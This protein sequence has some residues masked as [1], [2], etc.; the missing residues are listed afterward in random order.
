M[1]AVTQ[2]EAAADRHPRPLPL[3]SR[4]G[5]CCCLAAGAPDHHVGQWEEGIKVYK[6]SKSFYWGHYLLHPLS[7]YKGR[8]ISK[9]SLLPHH[10]SYRL[11]LTLAPPGAATAAPPAAPA[12]PAA[13]AT[14]AGNGVGSRAL[15]PPAP[16]AAPSAPSAAAAAGSNAQTTSAVVASAVLQASAAPATPAA[17]AEAE[18]ALLPAAVEAALLDAFV[19]YGKAAEQPPPSPA[20]HCDSTTAAV[21]GVGLPFQSLPGAAAVPDNTPPAPALL[22]LKR[23]VAKL[24]QQP[25]LS[26]RLSDSEAAAEAAAAAAAAAGGA[27]K[28][29]FR[30]LNRLVS[31]APRDPRAV[32]LMPVK[33]PAVELLHSA[34]M[35]QDTNSGVAAAAATCPATAAAGP[36]SKYPCTYRLEQQQ[37]QSTPLAAAVEGPTAPAVTVQGS[38]VPGAAALAGPAANEPIAPNSPAAPLG[39]QSSLLPPKRHEKQPVAA[40]KAAAAAVQQ[41][42]VTSG[43]ADT[44][45]HA[46]APTPSMIAAPGRGQ[47]IRQMEPNAVMLQ[48]RKQQQQQQ[49]DG[50]L[51]GRAVLGHGKAGAPGHVFVKQEPKAV[52][53]TTGNMYKGW[54]VANAQSELQLQPN[55]QQQQQQQ[56]QVPPLLA[57]A[58]AA[59]TGLRGATISPNAA[60]PVPQLSLVYAHE[61]DRVAAAPAAGPN[62]S[63]PQGGRLAEQQ[64]KVAMTA[65]AA[66]AAAAAATMPAPAAPPPAPAPAPMPPLAPP[67]ALA[68]TPTGTHSR[69]VHAVLVAAAAG[70]NIKQESAASERP[71]APVSPQSVLPLKRHAEQPLAAAAAKQQRQLQQRAGAAATKLP[72]AP[73]AELPAAAGTSGAQHSRHL[74]HKAQQPQQQ[75][76]SSPPPASR[77]PGDD[78]VC[79]SNPISRSNKVLAAAAANLTAP[80]QP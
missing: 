21:A 76:Q 53:H 41:Q 7:A 70:V 18:A 40:S 35:R 16:P 59:V 75:Q 11:T 24:Q 12:A 55:S 57:P 78:A 10:G 61:Q 77:P 15:I 73:K 50:V 45:L 42:Q 13:P 38:P 71:A 43:N 19:Q 17:A 28:Q 32:L 67:P 58:A 14:G 25:A 8:R 46:V 29:Q 72:G 30:G 4:R 36:R 69:T 5:I 44:N 22:P 26:S 47:H 68:A 49:Q 51:Q 65:A 79:A 74:G 54:Q 39:P 23:P 52:L 37:Q 33:R 66:A 64:Q 9:M 80:Q 6:S 62:S 27:S 60:P 20:S 63:K 1:P 34:T 48:Q 56:V 3:H 2:P 31:L